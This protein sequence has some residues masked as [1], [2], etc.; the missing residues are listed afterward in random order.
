MSKETSKKV[1]RESRHPLRHLTST[2]L[3]SRCLRPLR[4][5]L[6]A[7]RL[8]LTLAF[9]LLLAVSVVVVVGGVVG[10]LMGLGL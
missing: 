4:R 7:L 9:E 1:S 2:L 10:K 5:R 3:S 6:S 8:R